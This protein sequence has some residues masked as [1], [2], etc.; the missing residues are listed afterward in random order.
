MQSLAA[1]ADVVMKEFLTCPERAEDLYFENF[2]MVIVDIDG[3]PECALEFMEKVS[4]N[5]SMVI[6]YSEHPIPKS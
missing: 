2:D 5:G 4:G 3:S 1:A 6:A